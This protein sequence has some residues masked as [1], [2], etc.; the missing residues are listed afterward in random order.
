[1]LRNRRTTAIRTNAGDP[2][3]AH[4]FRRFQSDFLVW[5]RAVGLAEQTAAIRKFALDHFI[6][7][8]DSNGVSALPQLTTDVLERY[9]QY[10]SCRRKRNGLLLALNT[11]VT[12]LNPL[13][14]FCKWLA[15][16]GQLHLNPA[17][18]LCIPRV[19]R[20]LPAR[21]PTIAEVC[22][23]LAIPDISRP[24]GIRDRAILEMLYS[25]GIRRMELA[26]ISIHDLNLDDNALIVRSGK[27]NRDR[28]VP[29][30]A[31]AT[32]WVR[33]YLAE[34]RPILV[35]HVDES[36]LFLTDFGEPF[37]KNRLGD[38]VKKFLVRARV[39]SRGACHLFRHACATHMLENGADIR[40]IQALLG[41]ADLSTTQIYTHV[42]IA[43]LKEV[44]AATHPSSRFP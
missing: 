14:A 22:R 7:W 10:L 15:R 13:K 8:C 21:V 26:G 23:I 39:S 4:P 27:G 9:Q 36:V 25:T 31:S 12:R 43:K 33:R 44:H 16:N 28:M 32:G 2:T 6:Q 38:L 41:H 30:G 18:D 35:G 17:A 19:P 24:D 40:F 20:R 34:G 29:L 37:L 3:L 5:T 11:Q 1:M 42:C